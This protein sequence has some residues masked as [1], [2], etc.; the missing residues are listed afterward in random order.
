MPEMKSTNYIA[1]D[2]ESMY[3][4]MED[5]MS[6]DDPFSS[7]MLIDVM[8]TEL[9][10]LT[11]EFCPR[12]HG[13]PNLNLH[14][15]LKIVDKVGR[16]LANSHYQNRLLYCG[17]GESLLYKDLTESIKLFKKH[18]PWND[19]IHMVTNGDRLTYD[20]T[21]ELLDAG[22]NK[23]F[24]SMYSGP[25]QEDH[26]RELFAKVGLSEEQ[27]I[28]QHYYK[29]PEE[30]Y[31]FL[32]LSNRAGYLFNEKL[33]ELGCNIPFYAMSLHWDGDVLLCSHD[34]EK[35]QVMG[36]VMDTSVQDIWLKSQKLWKFRQELANGRGCHPCN[37]CNIKG[38][39]YGDVS[40]DMLFANETHLNPVIPVKSI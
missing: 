15:D 5:R 28:L 9:C 35:K 2:R 38:V 1:K 19:N 3:D 27:F 36:N 39:L 23:L 34:W 30:N 25:E 12:A 29:P 37:K 4:P 26:F 40:K 14:M 31:G 6:K 7:L 21:V 13:Y 33:P 32:Y 20:K 24:V 18:L 11:C 10:N 16:D 8:A 22:L 17:F